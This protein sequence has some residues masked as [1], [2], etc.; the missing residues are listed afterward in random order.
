M[1]YLVGDIILFC[2]FILF[3]IWLYGKMFSKS[4]EPEL[5]IVDTNKKYLANLKKKKEELEAVVGITKEVLILETQIT[6]QETKLKELETQGR[7]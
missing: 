4:K 2:F 1:L 3:L 6:A 5:S 7:K